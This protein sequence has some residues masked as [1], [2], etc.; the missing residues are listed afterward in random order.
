[1]KLIAAASFTVLLL[2]GC[3][4][5]AQ[6]GDFSLVLLHKKNDAE[7]L[8][9]AELDSIM[10]GHL[11]NIDRLAR[12]GKLIAA[13]PFEGGGGIFILKTTST[14]DAREWLAT[15]PGIRARRWDVEIVPYKPRIG[16]VC[17]ARE[18]Y[19]MV[20]YQFVHFK[21]N[22]TKSTIT[23]YPYLFF[24]HDD[25]LKK[26]EKTGNV[27]TEAIFGDY[28]GG[29]LILAGELQKEVIESDPA[30][31]AGVLTPDFKRLWIARGS[32]CEK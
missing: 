16:S 29:I 22:V 31:K 9:K 27:I 3:S 28:D 14:T 13:G 5:F 23:N 24:A 10:K 8:A 18:P 2:F 20:T 26:I 25:Y 11:A 15:D 19:E 17:L 1:M 32:F 12:E 6:T 30:V 4:A 7:T 21:T